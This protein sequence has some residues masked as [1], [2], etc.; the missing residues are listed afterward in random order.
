MAAPAKLVSHYVWQFSKAHSGPRLKQGFQ[1][2]ICVGTTVTQDD[3][4][5]KQNPHSI[6]ITQIFA[7]KGKQSITH[8]HT[9]SL[10][11]YHK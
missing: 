2:V 11:W 4:G 9:R 10:A 5:S 3:V 6:V 7:T 1:T 8:A